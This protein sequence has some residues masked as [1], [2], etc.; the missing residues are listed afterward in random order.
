MHVAYIFCA[1]IFLSL[2][3]RFVLCLKMEKC[4]EGKAS[5]LDLLT[6]LSGFEL[7]VVWLVFGSDKQI[8]HPEMKETEQCINAH[9]KAI[10]GI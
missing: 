7:F 4:L 6:V 5:T 10:T 2:C 9:C 3:V 1:F 8:S